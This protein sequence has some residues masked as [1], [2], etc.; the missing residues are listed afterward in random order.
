MRTRTSLQV[1]ILGGIIAFVCPMFLS[2]EESQLFELVRHA[3]H[4]DYGVRSSAVQRMVALLGQGADPNVRDTHGRTPLMLAADR[5]AVEAVTALIRGGAAP[6]LRDSE[7]WTALGIAMR[8]TLTGSGDSYAQVLIAQA[9]EIALVSGN[10]SR[11]DWNWK[12]FEAAY[13]QDLEGVKTALDHGANPDCKAGQTV[14]S[15]A[16]RSSLEPLMQLMLDAGAAPTWED[17]A[18]ASGN[19]EISLDVIKSLVKRGAGVNAPETN[20]TESSPDQTPLVAAVAG[21][22]VDLTEYLLA[23]GADPNARGLMGKT[24]LI[25]ACEAYRESDKA[26]TLV[27]LLLESGA[28]PLIKGG[29]WQGLNAIQTAARNGHSEAASLMA[30]TQKENPDE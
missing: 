26:L 11:E 4:S 7:G 23:Q 13:G 14:L 15:L 1:L 16:L 24:P 2:A 17:V 18:V 9:V 22:R 21:G 27:Q 10:H 20:N 29:G 25:A 8:K 3:S 12:L 5:G 6:E 28:D 19:H 30:S